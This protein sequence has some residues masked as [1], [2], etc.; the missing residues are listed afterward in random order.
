MD[1]RGLALLWCARLSR[2]RRS[3]R[4]VSP[5]ALMFDHRKS[6]LFVLWVC[7]FMLYPWLASHGTLLYGK[8][9]K[10]R[11][12]ASITLDGPLLCEPLRELCRTHER[13]LFGTHRFK[14]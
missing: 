7:Q 8:V 4:I 2:L 6:C 11:C 14:P 3:R 5:A 9:V 12:T 13:D 10:S 1:I